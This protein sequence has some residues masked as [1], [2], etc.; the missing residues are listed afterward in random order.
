[1]K[2]IISKLNEIKRLKTFERRN[3]K[4]NVQKPFY[5]LKRDE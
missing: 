2:R 1:M 3:D 5:L 4:E